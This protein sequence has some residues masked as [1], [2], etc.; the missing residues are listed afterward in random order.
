MHSQALPNRAPTEALKA[1]GG[2]EGLPQSKHLA[3]L[4]PLTCAFTP[5]A[6]LE[7]APYGLEV[8]PTPSTPSRR[9]P[10]SQVRSDASSS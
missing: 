9:V 6:G 4:K 10:S 7:P 2:A 1:P 8:N 3:R 5:P